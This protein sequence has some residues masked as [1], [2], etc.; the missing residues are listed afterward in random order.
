M[1]L[2]NQKRVNTLDMGTLLLFLSWLFLLIDLNTLVL[3]VILFFFFNVMNSVLLESQKLSD[4]NEV[5]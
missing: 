5:W 2:I 3:E 1:L 4:I